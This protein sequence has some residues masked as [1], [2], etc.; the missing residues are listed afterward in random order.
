MPEKYDDDGQ[1]DKLYES[2]EKLSS[3]HPVSFGGRCKPVTQATIISR[4]NVA[5]IVMWARRSDWATRIN[6]YQWYRGYR[7]ERYSAKSVVV[8]IPI[9][10]PPTPSV[11][12][13][14]LTLRSPI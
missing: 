4:K 11:T 10:S 1:S 5:H 8:T 9:G 7:E 12:G 3:Q 13:R 6:T 14:R 2:V